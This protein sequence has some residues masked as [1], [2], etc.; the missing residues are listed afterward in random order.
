MFTIRLLRTVMPAIVCF[1]IVCVLK[2]CILFTE[3][4]NMHIVLYHTNPWGV[5]FC[6]PFRDYSN[7]PYCYNTLNEQRSLRFDM[8]SVIHY[9]ACIRSIRRTYAGQ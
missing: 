1:V 6:A 7:T 5:R 2:V 3:R 8:R 4:Y 9:C